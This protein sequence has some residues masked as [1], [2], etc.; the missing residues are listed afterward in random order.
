MDN[1]DINTDNI[2]NYLS[3]GCDTIYREFD[4]TKGLKSQH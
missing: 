1:G 2:L 4:K 3:V